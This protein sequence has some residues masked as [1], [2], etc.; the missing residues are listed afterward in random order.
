MLEYKEFGKQGEAD[1]GVLCTVFAIFF[2]SL[3]LLRSKL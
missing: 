1:L 2:I 3:K